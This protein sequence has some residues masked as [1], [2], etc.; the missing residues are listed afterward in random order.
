MVIDVARGHKVK[1]NESG[2]WNIVLQAEATNY[3]PLG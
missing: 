2:P 3:M 1:C